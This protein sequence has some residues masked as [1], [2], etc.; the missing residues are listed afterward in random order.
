MMGKQQRAVY[1]HLLEP[2]CCSRQSYHSHLLGG[3]VTTPIHEISGI[4]RPFFYVFMLTFTFLL[5]L[6]T[7]SR[8]SQENE[9]ENR[10]ENVKIKIEILK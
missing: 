5:S 10:N 4:R 1:V 8:H 2:S 3:L 7:R 6:N 9:N